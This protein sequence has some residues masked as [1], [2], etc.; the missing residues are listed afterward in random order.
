MSSIA[1]T[2]VTIVARASCSKVVKRT[3]C[4]STARSSVSHL[5]N[6]PAQ[7]RFSTT[8]R[9]SAVHSLGRE[10]A[11][12]LTNSKGDGAGFSTVAGDS[13]SSSNRAGVWCVAGAA[14][15]TQRSFGDVPMGAFAVCETFSEPWRRSL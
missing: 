5:F 4:T 13:S 7:P 2:P 9:A 10:Q 12:P 8:N 15:G 1:R 14:G 6:E 3:V 11:Q